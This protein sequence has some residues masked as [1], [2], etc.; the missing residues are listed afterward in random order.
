MIYYLI[1][2]TFSLALLLGIY[3]LLL[4]SERAFVFNRFY[5]VVSLVLSLSIPGL[6]I[7]TTDSII[8][9]ITTVLSKS[10]FVH[11]I[12]SQATGFNEAILQST[13][14]AE[15]ITYVL[16]LNAII[17]IMLLLKY[18]Y[19]LLK[20]KRL[21]KNKGP[22]L[23]SLQ[24]VLLDKSVKP[25][26]FFKLLYL[27]RDDLESVQQNE[28][29]I[30]HEKAHSDQ[31]HSLDVLGIELIKCFLWFNP[32]IW[33]YKKEIIENHEY[34]ADNYAV[35]KQNNTEK[36]ALN[37]IASVEGEN[38]YPLSS[39]FGFML[40]K[41]RIKMLTQSNKTTMSNIM[42]ITTGAVLAVSI[43]TIS[44]FNLQKSPAKIIEKEIK[45]IV[46]NTPKILPIKKKD[47][48]KIS[49]GF[50][51]RVHPTFKVEKMHNG[52]DFIAK[53]GTA[54]LATA[55]GTVTTSNF[56]NGYGNHIIIKHDDSYETQ[57]AHMSS[58]N[59]KEGD[60]VKAGQT[61][62]VIGNSGQSLA[63]HLHYEVIKDGVHVNPADF[64]E[65]E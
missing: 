57:Y 36:Y 5:L 1:Q 6:Q 40:I 19:N 48:K 35:N 30:Y 60:H 46:N 7:E 24:T 23:D 14:S 12:E 21:S 49:A 42:K 38:G 2:S 26:S 53:E 64:F 11:T 55:D 18:A 56:S 22:V 59:V 16:S 13:N 54:I 29:L 61:I 43:I 47:I 44:A 27:K 4:K 52:V 33:I 8:E 65:F 58:L 39:G 62:G 17:T 37:L 41:K 63:I 28:S 50:G 45:E 25:F 10:E 20:L 34:L 31:L 9:P 15:W 32:F 51:H 3:L